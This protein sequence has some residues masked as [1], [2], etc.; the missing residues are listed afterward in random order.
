[1]TFVPKLNYDKSDFHPL[2]VVDRGN[3]TQLQLGDNINKITLSVKGLV[4]IC[5]SSFK[6]LVNLWHS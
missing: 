6:N 5:A 1:M 4:S 2:E 3:E